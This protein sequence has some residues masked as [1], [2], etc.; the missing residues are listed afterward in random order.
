MPIDLFFLSQCCIFIRS[1]TFRSCVLQSKIPFLVVIQN[2]LHPQK[3]V[4][5]VNITSLKRFWIV[6]VIVV[7]YSS[8]CDG[9]VTAPSMMSGLQRKISPP[10]I[11]FGNFIANPRMRL[12]QLTAFFSDLVQFVHG[13]P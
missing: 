5:M 12:A 13:S 6:G 8:R 9:K 4:T 3:F 10:L 7:S 2:L 11:F 1:S